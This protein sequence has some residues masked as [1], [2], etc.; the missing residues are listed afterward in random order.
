MKPMSKDIRKRRLV[1]IVV[2]ALIQ[3]LTLVSPYLMGAI[4]DDYIPGRK[5]GQIAAGIFFFVL[6]PFVTI[7]LQTLYNYL[8]IKYV[9]KKGNEIALQI[10][11]RLVY[12]EKS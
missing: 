11:E 5:T 9:R 2:F 4:I 12:Q 6:I 1:S 8:T 7:L 3:A 10:M